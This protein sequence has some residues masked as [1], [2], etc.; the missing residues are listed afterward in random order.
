MSY[1]VYISD[2]C[3]DCANVIDYI[4]GENIACEILNID[5]TDQELPMNIFI[6]PA[7]AQGEKLLAYGEK[8]IIKKLAKV[9]A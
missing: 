3:T 7:L 1:T 6:I 8:D 5:D 9:S 4:Q 2:H